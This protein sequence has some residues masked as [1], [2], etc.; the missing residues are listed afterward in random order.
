MLVVAACGGGPETVTLQRSDG[1]QVVGTLVEA[2]D[3]SITI[4]EPGGRQVVVPRSQIVLLSS[5]EVAAAGGGEGGDEGGEEI[6]PEPEGDV[7]ESHSPDG[8]TVERILAAG[9]LL[10][11]TLETPVDTAA[12]SPGDAVRASLS[13][14]VTADGVE[15]LPAGTLLVGAVREVRR[16]G[17]DDTPARVTLAFDEVRPRGSRAGLPVAT[18]PILREGR[19]DRVKGGKKLIRRLGKAVGKEVEPLAHDLRLEAGTAIEVVLQTPLAIRSTPEAS[20][21]PPRR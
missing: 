20:S 11:A 10:P 21:R 5:G 19:V 3:D 9:T 7:R 15:V 2:D 13:R 17:A 16:A 12:A 4:L 18:R 1:S 8:G 6:G 14:G